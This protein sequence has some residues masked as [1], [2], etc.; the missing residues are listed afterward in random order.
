MGKSK[1][2]VGARMDAKKQVKLCRFCGK[3]VA[4]S[5]T[6]EGGRKKIVRTCCGKVTNAH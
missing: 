3:P 1:T 6:L 2:N 5:L 4:T